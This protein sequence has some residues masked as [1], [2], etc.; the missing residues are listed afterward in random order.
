MNPAAPAS[1]GPAAEGAGAP[2][3]S[4]L[5]ILVALTAAAIQMV[6]LARYVPRLLADITLNSDWV[7]SMV[8]A[9]RLAMT[10]GRSFI[11]TGV[12]GFYS[13]VWF[14]QATLHL[15][16]HRL[17]WVVEPGMLTLL[18]AGLLALAAYRAAGA[19][20]AAATM[21]L[22]LAMAPITLAHLLAPA[23]RQP[24]W[25][26][27]CML[28]AFV[29]LVAAAPEPGSG[30][31]MLMA[32]G[33]GLV[34][35]VNLASDPLMVTVAGVV[36]MLAAGVALP[37]AGPRS[38]RWVVRP[39]VLATAVM[40]VVAAI[41]NLAAKHQGITTTALPGGPVSFAAQSRIPA[42]ASL[43]VRGIAQNLN[44]WFFGLPVD[45]WSLLLA[46]SFVIGV[47]VLVAVVVSGTRLFMAALSGTEVSASPLSV[48]LAFWAVAMVVVS[49]AFTLSSVPEDQSEA[50]YLVP[51]FFV[52]AAG[53]PLLASRFKLPGRLLV[54]VA[55]VA[56][57]ASA[58]HGLRDAALGHRLAAQYTQQFGQLQEFLQSRGLTRGYG[59]YWV[60][61]AV[62]WKSHM[63]VDIIPYDQCGVGSAG[64]PSPQTICF[65]LGMTAV[66][67]RP[68]RSFVISDPEFPP[69]PRLPEAQFGTPVEVYSVGRFTVR[70]FPDDV[71]QHL[72]PPPGP[73]P[74]E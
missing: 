35:G 29:V 49:A 13:T 2:R 8:I 37:L 65:H 36:P 58:G 62:S 40:V 52:V 70:V 26:T 66:R 48:A 45:I 14:E 17:L 41:A 5:P 9:E 11:A 71:G 47:A 30:R 21:A 43:L 22:A 57:C 34:A 15:P 4:R 39:V 73:T 55:A 51:A 63:A 64:Q 72:A 12:Y 10:H 24:T 32:A 61:S 69:E 16:G 23:N 60:A 42:N 56:L 27:M 20:A 31:T 74:F 7:A 38:R 3:L 54:S 1:G 44:G 67:S 33:V 59:P 53:L 18:G 19:W 68:G 46:G 25:F 6:A 28:A 50:R